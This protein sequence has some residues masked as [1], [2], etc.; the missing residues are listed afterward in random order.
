M[1]YLTVEKF[2]SSLAPGVSYDLKRVSHMLRMKVNQ[3]LSSTFT[4]LTNIGRERQPLKDEIQ[5]SEEEAKIMP[6]TCKHDAEAHD[7]DTGRCTTT[8][9]DCRKPKKPEQGVVDRLEELSAQEITILVSE[10]WPVRIR[11][12]VK[13]INGLDID[14]KPATVESLLNDG[15]EPLIAELGGR[16]NGLF[17]LSLDQQLAFKSP[18]TGGAQAAGETNGTSAPTA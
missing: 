9:C 12:V 17:N 6:C 15:P 16:V 3:E 4:K 18:T 5:R 10:M 14:G 1:N 7:K 8:P 13:S 2:E 11:A